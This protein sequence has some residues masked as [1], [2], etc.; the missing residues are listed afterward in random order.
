MQIDPCAFTPLRFET[1]PPQPMRGETDAGALYRQADAAGIRL[2]VI[3]YAPGFLA[4]HWCDIGHF[5]YVLSGTVTIELK[6]GVA[7][8]LMAGEAFLVSSHGDA[9]HR[10]RTEQGARLLIL[11]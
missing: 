7:H 5:A 2:R 11:D 1:L 3:D 6:D 9:A 8:H 10:V 4:D